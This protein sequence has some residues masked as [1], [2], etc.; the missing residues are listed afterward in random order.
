MLSIGAVEHILEYVRN[1]WTYTPPTNNCVLMKDVD[2][3][4]VRKNENQRSWDL[5]K[6]SERCASF[7]CVYLC[8]GSAGPMDEENDR[9][10]GRR[11]WECGRIKCQHKRNLIQRPASSFT[12]TLRLR[13]F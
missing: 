6:D 2:W 9:C 11:C 8:L 3:I 12:G 13:M 1:K 7:S 10:S 4:Y 5:S